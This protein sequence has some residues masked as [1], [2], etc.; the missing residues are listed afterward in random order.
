MRKNVWLVLGLGFALVSG[1]AAMAD[2]WDVQTQ[3]DNGAGTTENELV[4]GSDQ[5][6]DLGALTGPPVA[7]DDDWYQISQKPFSSY[8]IVVD[9]TSGDIG[10]GLLVTRT[11]SD[12]S[13]VLQ[14]SDPVGVGYSRSLRWTNE[15]S[16]EINTQKVHVA[17]GS[18][19]TNCG[20]DDVY[21]L[22]SYETTYAV[23]RFNNTGSQVTVL[24]LQNPTSYTI[25]GTAYF[26][27]ATGTPVGNAPI[28]LA[29]KALMV[30]VTSTVAPTSG[31]MTIVHNGRYGD[32]SGKTVAL[33]PA[34]GF[35]FDS[36]MIPRVH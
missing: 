26:W 6:H 25:A 19:T 2:V 28:N 34:T 11:T 30:L 7:A 23:P 27:S 10:T 16:L 14:S 17:S 35:S 13:T 24:L 33:E 31:A 1:R 3:N 36:P 18:C 5:L 9:A 15:T 20:A 29:P 4:H 21:R 22:R 12:G 32:L 8:E